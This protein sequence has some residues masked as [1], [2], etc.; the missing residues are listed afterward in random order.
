MLGLEITI[1]ALA[2]CATPG[3]INIVASISGAQNGIRANIPFVLGATVGLFFVIIISDFGVSHILKTNELFANGVT[4]VGSVYILYLAFL[5]S[6]KNLAIETDS[7][8]PQATSFF[9]GALLQLINP[10]A[11]LVSMSGLAM[12]L[13]SSAQSMF[14]FYIFVFSV[15]CFVSVFLW[16]CLG[17]LIAAK[18]KSSYLTIF[19]RLMAT[20]LSTLVLY[21]L[22]DMLS[23]YLR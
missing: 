16:V 7:E 12:Y 23:P 18:L 19:S 6:K 10:K 1:F 15:A 8:A 21:N 13:N 11:W 14:A 17:S 5:M 2:T 3:P 22:V 4:L 20:M 9:Q